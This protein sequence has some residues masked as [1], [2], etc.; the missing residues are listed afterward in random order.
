MISFK[1]HRYEKSLIL[2]CVRWYLAYSISYRSLEEMMTERGAFVDHTNIYR[3]VQK[4]APLL[5]SIFRKNHKKTVGNSW[6]K[7]ETYI[8]VIGEWKYL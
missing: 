7:D 4:F 5:E 6:R 3:W 1:G 8:N 2:M